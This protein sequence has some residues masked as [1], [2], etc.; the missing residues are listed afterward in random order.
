MDDLN[1]KRKRMNTIAGSKK[2]KRVPE[3]PELN[4]LLIM[5]GLFKG[6]T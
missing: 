3:I 2:N 5:V 6:L 1:G 4:F